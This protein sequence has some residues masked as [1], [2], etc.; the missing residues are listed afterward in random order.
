MKVAIT[1]A[2]RL[3]VFVLANYWGENQASAEKAP[4]GE[5]FVR[6]HWLI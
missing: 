4:F 2:Y 1:T 5:C 3:V 6:T